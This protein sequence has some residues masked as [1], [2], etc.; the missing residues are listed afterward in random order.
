[1]SIEEQQDTGAPEFENEINASNMLLEPN[2]LDKNSIVNTGIGIEF[3]NDV[4]MTNLEIQN[5]TQEKMVCEKECLKT[6]IGENET[7]PIIEHQSIIKSIDNQN[8]G[9]PKTESF[10]DN[11]EMTDLSLSDQTNQDQMQV[12]KQV[13]KGQACDDIAANILVTGYTEEYSLRFSETLSE[14]ESFSKTVESNQ[15]HFKRQTEN[16]DSLT[17]SNIEFHKVIENKLNDILKGQEDDE[18]M[19]SEREFEPGPK[20]NFYKHLEN[21]DCKE[22]TN[23]SVLQSG[24]KEVT[25]EVELARSEEMILNDKYNFKPKKT[26]LDAPKIVDPETGM[27]NFEEVLVKPGVNGLMERFYTHLSYK[28][29]PKKKTPVELK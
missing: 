6:I 13:K 21:E 26:I 7:N 3:E 29:K 11:T 2:L 15:I 12:E 22:S 27:I 1:M 20:N 19:E 28:K 8:S 4:E 10:N 5:T 25:T 23:E 17:N 9:E 14:Y 18:I 24:E 16:K